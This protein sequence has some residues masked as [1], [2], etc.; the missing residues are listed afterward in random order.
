MFHALQT[1]VWNEQNDELHGPVDFTSGEKVTGNCWIGGGGVR[2]FD[3]SERAGG[4][5]KNPFPVGNRT[6]VAQSVMF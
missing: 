4:Q 6:P 2:L 5:K 3:W 1:L